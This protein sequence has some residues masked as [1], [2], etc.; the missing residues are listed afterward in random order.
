M[1]RA[2]LLALASAVLA[3]AAPAATPHQTPM[4]TPPNPFIDKGACPF[5]CCTYRDWTTTKPVTLLD[6]PDGKTKVV[7]IPAKT[8]VH[9]VTGDVYSIPISVKA[10]HAF[11]DSP[12]KKGDTFYAM[13]SAGEGF[14]VVW[15]KGKTYTVDMSEAAGNAYLEKACNMWWIQIKTKDGKTGWVLNDDQFDNQ[16][17]CG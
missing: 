8:V 14:W 5:E 10:T 6:K 12:I 11:E 2:L 1:K 17:S 9:G 3:T 7:S 16:D 15:F 4:S 13:H